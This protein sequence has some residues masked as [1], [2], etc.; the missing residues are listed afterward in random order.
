MEEEG[1]K[2]IW[3]TAL[4]ICYLA[5]RQPSREVEWG[6]LV[7]KAKDWLKS[8]ALQIL[9]TTSSEADKMITDLL[10]AADEVIKPSQWA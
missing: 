8:K 1:A 3:S 5:K 2:D 10:A 7:D 9:G 4:V 6:L